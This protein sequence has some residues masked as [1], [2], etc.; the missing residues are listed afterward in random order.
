MMNVKINNKTYILI[1]LVLLQ[2]IATTIITNQAIMV[3]ING[4]EKVNYNYPNTL[5]FIINGLGISVV[6]WVFYIIKLVAKEQESN[7]K[8]NHSTEV[9]QALR[10]Q[11]H[12][13][14]NHL[15]VIAGLIQLEKGHK[16]LNYIQKVSGKTTKMFSI[17]TVE[18]PEAAAILYRK[19]AIAESKGISVELDIGSGL[20]DIAIDSVE[21]C[22]ILFNLIDNA[23]YELEQCRENE[24]ILTIDITEQNNQY[25]FAIGNSYPIL[26]SELHD[27]I[28]EQGYSTKEGSAHGYGLSIVKKI[29][30]KNR[31]KITVESYDGVGTIFTAFL[32]KK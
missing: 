30:Q 27:K 14:H 6:V 31:G 1:L 20:E 7:R 10:G 15:N 17:S 13:F 24:K 16:A 25:I 22:T 12:D 29:T 26:P 11:K 3:S 19:C 28:F 32:P 9:I 5:N 4:V 21:L 18:N 2:S 23:I 8:L